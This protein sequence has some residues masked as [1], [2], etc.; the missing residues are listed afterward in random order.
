M[1]SGLDNGA[2]NTYAGTGESAVIQLVHQLMNL[3]TPS[4]I[5]LDEPESSLH[6]DAQRKLI[7]FLVQISFKD[8]HQVFISTHSPYIIE[9]PRISKNL[10]FKCSPDSNGKVEIKKI[11]DKESAFIEVGIKRYKGI[12]YVE[13][14]FTKVVFEAILAHLG[15][16][17]SYSV[18]YLNGFTDFRTKVFGIGNGKAICIAD[19][20]KFK[21]QP[22]QYGPNL[23]NLKQTFQFLAESDKLPFNI[24]G[25]SNEE[26][27]QLYNEAIKNFMNGVVYLPYQDIEEFILKLITLP[28][29]D[30]F[31]VTPQDR[32]QELERFF[33]SKLSADG[34]TSPTNL[35]R[36]ILIKTLVNGGKENEYYIKLKMFISEDVL[37]K[38]F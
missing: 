23:D 21:E 33:I 10:V 31:I 24:D 27:C 25:K 5:I 28:E 17:D 37:P 32:K 35:E 3:K 6:V 1:V 4:I 19:S 38:F 9:N 26:L 8:K 20:D 12:I 15:Y 7:D 30:T 22:T 34:Q 2:H 36:G 16:V 18:I 29:A 14:F 11:I 13:D